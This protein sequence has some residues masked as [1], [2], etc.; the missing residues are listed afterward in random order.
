[1]NT[2]IEKI[3]RLYLQ[4]QQRV[5][6]DTR[7]II[8]ESIFF[9]LKG[10]NF[11][12][13]TYAMDAIQKG[14]SWAIVDNPEI[15]EK[16]D[17]CILVNDVLKTLQ[18]LAQYHRTQ[19]N[20]PVIAITG[21]N[22]KTTTKELVAAVL[23]KKYKVL[24][25]PGN[26]NNHIG[27][28]LTLLQIQT[29][30]QIAVIEMGA[31]HPGE[32]KELCHIASPDYGIITSIGKEHLEGFGDIETVKKTNGE[33]YDYLLSQNKKIFLH[34]DNAD[35][36]D[37]LSKNKI[38]IPDIL[39]NE[40]TF[41]IYSDVGKISLPELYR[42]RKITIGEY[43]ENDKDIFMQFKWIINKAAY[44]EK[45]ENAIGFGYTIL[46]AFEKR[47]PVKTHLLAYHNFIN[48]LSAVCVGEYLGV[49]ENDINDAIANYIPDKNRMQWIETNKGNKI[50]LDAYNANPTSMMAA[51]QFFKE[52]NIIKYTPLT[53]DNKKINILTNEEDK[54]VILGDMFE[55]GEHSE[56]E[57]TD[58]IR[59]LKD[60]FAKSRI[61]LAGKEFMK[62]AEK[63]KLYSNIHC[64]ESTEE[65][66]RH[67]LRLNITGQFI[68]IKASRGMQL[69]KILEVL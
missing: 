32:I 9:A 44:W 62:A 1:M 37:I 39:Q 15:A 26:Y 16:S 10:S 46:P 11:D 21:S 20:K 41:I 22:G 38:S 52:K 60:N 68:L 55:L 8:P 17:R 36:L 45:F 2:A 40:D 14:C 27:L 25:T 6:T 64:F 58:I 35:L 54:I 3:Y 34:L 49:N 19:W 23:S 33:L 56:K 42:D 48:A 4:Q 53:S 12:G 57:H 63:E 67:L 50:I 66:K 29:E 69:E 65:L 59:Y 31:N 61:F 51:L 30:H 43:V 18:Q 28:P 47:P 24:S 13:N 7:K 5:C